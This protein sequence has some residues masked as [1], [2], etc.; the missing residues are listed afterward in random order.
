[1]EHMNYTLLDHL[2][3]TESVKGID[4]K[5]VAMRRSNIVEQFRGAHVLVT[6]GTGF[7]GQVLM[8]KLLRTCQIEKLYIIMRPKK[9]MTENE[10]IEKIFGG[11]V[12]I[13][14]VLI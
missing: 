9:G 10:R 6:G 14:F 1:M 7:M 8:E 11:P 2:Y 12:S 4:K 3:A 5:S 13:L